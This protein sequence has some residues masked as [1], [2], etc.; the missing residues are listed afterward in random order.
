M[1]IEARKKTDILNRS[2]SQLITTVWENVAKANTDNE[3]AYQLI[4]WLRS[5]CEA[6]GLLNL[7]AYSWDSIIIHKTLG[8]EG[9]E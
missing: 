9:R 4:W 6:G 2:V 7:A 5:K 1:Q 3:G 8:H